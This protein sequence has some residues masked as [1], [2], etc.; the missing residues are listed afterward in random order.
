[1]RLKDVCNVFLDGDWIENKDQ[2]PAGIRL[3]QTGNIGNGIFL[4]KKD[5]FQNI[6]E[7]ESL[8][9]LY[10]YIF[11]KLLFLNFILPYRYH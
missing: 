4:E 3:I 11:I 1:M 2:S 7:N 8:F 5:S 6:T 9:P 10:F